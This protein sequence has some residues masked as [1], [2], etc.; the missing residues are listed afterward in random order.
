MRAAAAFAICLILMTIFAGDR[1]L[2]AVFQARRQA[3]QLSLDIE[4]LRDENARLRHRAE[5]LRSDPAVI[6]RVARE[7]LGLARAGEL[8]VFR[9][10]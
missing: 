3:H 10:R 9:S 6:E 4:R 7:T 1:G 8:V 5:A 2:P